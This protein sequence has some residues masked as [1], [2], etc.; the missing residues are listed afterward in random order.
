M[1]EPRDGQRTGRWQHPTGAARTT[2]TQP[3]AGPQGR[4]EPR[5]SVGLALGASRR[6]HSTQCTCGGLVS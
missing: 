6:G 5:L 1:G 4:P 3:V 2:A